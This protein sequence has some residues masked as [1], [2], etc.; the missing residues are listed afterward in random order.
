M[1]LALV[2]EIF[3]NYQN[4]AQILKKDSD[5]QEQIHSAQLKLRPYKIGKLGQMLEWPEEYYE[6]EPGHRHLSFLYGVYPGAQITSENLQMF[7]AARKGLERR[8]K[9]GGSATGWS[10]AWKIN[11]W[12][13]L[14]DGQE[15]Y[16][17]VVSQL[18]KS[19]YPNLFDA[20]PPFQIDGNF[21]GTSGIAEMLLQSHDS[22]L[23]FLPAIPNIWQ[24]GS[25]QGLC[26]RGGFKVD[27]SWKNNQ[28]K[29]V[30]ILATK[31]I[32]CVFELK[33]RMQ[34]QSDNKLIELKPVKENIY[35]FQAKNGK[36]YHLSLN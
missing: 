13:R 33:N 19:T 15:A 10:C 20:H 16:N 29:T 8:I 30:R 26:A 24:E 5:L 11:L 17:L 22:I 9:Y 28:L 3:Q 25:V 36:V 6:P 21:G 35:E 12:A 4:T 7:Q 14:R 23:H 31:D 18:R 34:L 27:L 1:D 32:T 2:W